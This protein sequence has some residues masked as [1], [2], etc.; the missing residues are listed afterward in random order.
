MNHDQDKLKILLLRKRAPEGV[1]P[2]AADAW[3]RLSKALKT[4]TDLKD[5]P[6]PENSP[7]E[8]SA[9]LEEWDHIFLD[10]ALAD[11]SALES[12]P[13]SA[14]TLVSAETFAWDEPETR[15]R[16][17][18]AY[19][20]HPALILEG[21]S[22]SDLVRVLHLYLM[23]KRLAGV[24]PM[25]EKGALIVGEKLM[26]TYNVGSL[27]DRLCAHLDSFEALEL[28]KRIPDLRQTLSALLLEGLRCAVAANVLYP[29]V[30]FQASASRK[31]L[32][33]NLR[34]PKGGL[35]LE[36]LL[37][38]ILSGA[39]LFWSQIWQCSD[40]L[41]LT[42]HR[43]HDEL[44]VMV[45]L[46]KPDRGNR[47][48]FNTLLSKSLDRSSQK[49]SLLEAPDTYIFR[50]LADIHTKAAADLLFTAGEESEIDFGSLPEKVVGQIQSLEEKCKVLQ[51]SLTHK[52][53]A[54]QE[55]IKKGL[56][57]THELGQKRGELL[58]AIK[59]LETQSEASEK[60]IRDLEERI[61][62]AKASAAEAASA[63]GAAN[64]AGLQESLSRVEA[65]LRASESEK[66]ALRE[67]VS[68]E[69]KR[70][71]IFEQKYSALYKDIS[72]KERE[73]NE[74]KTSFN[75][76][77]KDQATKQTSP[78]A[79]SDASGASPEKVKEYEARE[80]VQRQEIRKLTFK[81]E[82]QEKYVKAQQAEAAE[83]LN[84]LEQKLKV[85]KSKELE[86]LKKVEELMV[87]LK[88]AHKAA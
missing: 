28:K 55:S 64:P 9:Y 24:A 72:L 63:K 6:L 71:A 16:T 81:L 41:I 27:L 61:A 57:L 66:N 10:T 20:R 62:H 11:W 52:D 31:K 26:D 39:D 37:R 7:L 40:I 73:I 50:Q 23:P 32:A 45:V 68:H 74:L 48:R 65:M 53:S 18:Q 15:L 43:Q 80:L 49:E 17:L 22:T 42:D 12:Q 67:N 30:D 34:F 56:E 87:A 4:F 1:A 69:Q 25:M 58:R 54:L 29:Y 47:P 36:N 76:I 51:D 2:D 38:Q 60:R 35:N 86:L 78:A 8:L 21:L 84:M 14:L 77:R 5:V 44:E 13:L 70:V 33:V 59:T 88:R 3:S 83:K 75:K 85:A 82:N 79:A 46:C 19:S